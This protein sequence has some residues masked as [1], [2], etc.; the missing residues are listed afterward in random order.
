MYSDI[1]NRSKIFKNHN[2]PFERIVVN[3]IVNNYGH[4]LIDL[5]RNNE[6]FI[7]NSRTR[8]DK[9]KDVTC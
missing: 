9:C 3:S 4:Q 2:I 8:C 5:Y 6:M 1:L 7:V